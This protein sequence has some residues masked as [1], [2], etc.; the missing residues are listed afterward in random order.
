MTTLAQCPQLPRSRHF[1]FFIS[2]S[3]RF[4]NILHVL[5]FSLKFLKSFILYCRT[6]SHFVQGLTNH[7]WL[8]SFHLL[9][10]TFH[11]PTAIT[12]ADDRIDW[13]YRSSII[14][15]ICSEHLSPDWAFCW[16]FRVRSLPALFS[17]IKKCRYLI[18]VFLYSQFQ[19][20]VTTFSLLSVSSIVQR[21]RKQGRPIVV[22]FRVHCTATSQPSNQ[23]HLLHET[24]KY[25]LK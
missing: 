5:L 22:W 10:I 17:P 23:L 21:V 6:N 19:I 3:L 7:S 16:L 15:V 24:L 2:I 11:Y 18:V 20:F 8:F 14:V 4:Y 1:L 12:V 13:F 9:Y 25:L